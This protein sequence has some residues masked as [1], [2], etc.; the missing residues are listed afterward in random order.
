MTWIATAG[1]GLEGVLAREIRGLGYPAVDVQTSRV[2]FTGGPEAGVRANLWLRTAGRVRLRAGSFEAAD[3]DQLFDGTGALPWERYLSR[4]AAFP[5][6]CR[7]VNSDIVSPSDCQAVVKKAIAGR[8]GRLYGMNR[9]PEDGPERP[10]EVH[11]HRGRVTLSIDTSGD[12]LHRRGYRVLNAG[13]ALRETLAAAMVLLSGWD[14]GTPLAD[15]FCGSGTICVEAAL[16]GRAVAPGLG[17]SFA[18]EDWPLLPP[19]LWRAAREEAR[20]RMNRNPLDIRGGDMDEEALSMAR[21]HLRKAGASDAIRLERAD[22]RRFSSAR[23]RGV[24]VTNPPYGKRIWDAKAAE[25]LYREL[26]PAMDA[27][28]GWSFHILSP[29]PRLE[30][31]LGRRALGRRTLYNGPIPCRFYQFGNKPPHPASGGVPDAQDSR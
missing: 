12:P 23:S 9:L 15:P 25:R 26:R 14:P 4:E 21:T 16:I 17:R 10:V 31:L 7:L 28:P 1:Y 18:A 11:I 3:F 19:K 13:A 5:V 27:L 8:L 20:D 2:T 22:A 30:A 24:W 29:H 6:T